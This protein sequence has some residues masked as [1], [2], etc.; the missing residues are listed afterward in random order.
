MVS[1][2]AAL[3]VWVLLSVSSARLSYVKIALAERLRTS[4]LQ[5]DSH[6]HC[7]KDLAASQK[8]FAKSLV[9]IAQV[10]KTLRRY[11]W[12]EDE[13]YFA[14]CMLSGVKGRFSR[15]PLLASLA[16]SL[17]KYHP[18]IAVTLADELLEEVSKA[19]F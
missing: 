14:R 10:V 4:R 17:S 2:N 13:D 6:S 18:T 16:A 15:I 5:Q 1:G 9:A 3:Q 8:C 12:K 7:P 11:S 19:K